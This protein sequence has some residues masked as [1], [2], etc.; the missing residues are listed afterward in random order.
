MLKIFSTNNIPK[1]KEYISVPWDK[2]F[3]QNKITKYFD[4]SDEKIVHDV[5]QTSLINSETIQGK[6][7]EMPIGVG[8]LSEGCK[9]LLCI[10]YA[11]KNKTIKNY[12]F[13]ITSCGGNAVA[14]LANTIAKD[15]NILVC[16]EHGDLGMFNNTNISVDGNIFNDSI[17]AS[18]YLIEQ[19]VKN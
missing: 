2:Y 13:N 19:G 8:K 7:S 14:Y 15:V 12:V 10:N 9:T 16:I 3:R 1:D 18:T 6:F 11:I 5:E 4:E 17:K